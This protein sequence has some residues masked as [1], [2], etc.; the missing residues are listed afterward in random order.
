[1]LV[2]RRTDCLWLIAQ[3]AHGWLSGRLAHEWRGLEGGG[4]GLP[5]SLVLATGLHDLAWREADRS[6]LLN[7]ANGQPHD[8]IDF[9]SEER[10]RVYG[11]GLDA[12]TEVDPFCARLVSLHYCT[13]PGME[14]HTAF[15]ESERTRRQALAR[16]AVCGSGD[17]GSDEALAEPLAYLKLF[18]V[19]SLFIGLTA[20]AVDRSQVPSWLD[21]E[22]V[23]RAPGGLRFSLTWRDGGLAFDP[24]PFRAPFEMSVTYRRLDRSHFETQDQLDRAWRAAGDQTWRVCVFGGGRTS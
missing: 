12:L 18:D 13:I 19:L 22:A 7:R 15:Q 6:P 11:A 20:P 8:F 21:P 17:D 24:F 23:G 2:Q 4:E 10:L 16:G 14:V 9:P 5:Y 3:H 1:M